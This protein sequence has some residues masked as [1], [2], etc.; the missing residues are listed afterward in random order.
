MRLTLGASGTPSAALGGLFGSSFAAL[1]GPW[2]PLVGPWLSLG[3]FL[4]AFG[5]SFAA[6]GGPWP[7]LVG[8]WLPLGAFSELV[9]A[10]CMLLAGSSGHQ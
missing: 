8:P 10:F 7:R 4:A 2:P 1:G 5:C 6:F 9:D 3:A